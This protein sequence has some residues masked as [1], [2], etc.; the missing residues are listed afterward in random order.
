M[1]TLI[2]ELIGAVWLISAAAATVV[3]W[4]AHRSALIV[5]PL[6]EEIKSLLARAD[7]ARELARRVAL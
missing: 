6:D 2:I 5:D 7:Q 1:F 4:H 3:L